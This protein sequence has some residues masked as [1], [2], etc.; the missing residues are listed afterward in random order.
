LSHERGAPHTETKKAALADAWMLRPEI[1]AKYP[2]SPTLSHQQF[3]Q[4]LLD[5]AGVTISNKAQLIQDLNNGTKTRAQVL[6]IIAESPEVNAKFYKQAF[7]TMEYFGYLRRD[8]EDC[9]NPNNWT[10]GD[11]INAVIFSIT[12]ASTWVSIRPR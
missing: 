4:T 12:T 9:H 1:Q 5:T 6:R 2:A 11:P 8:P 3:V 7:V 10:G